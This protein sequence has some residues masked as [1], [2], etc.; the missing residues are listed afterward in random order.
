MPADHPLA[1]LCKVYSNVAFRADTVC[2]MALVALQPPPSR[3]AWVNSRVPCRII[4]QIHWKIAAN[5][6]TT[7]PEQTVFS[8]RQTEI[9]HSFSGNL[10][11]L[12]SP[13]WGSCFCGL[14]GPIDGGLLVN[15]CHWPW[16]L[17]L[18]VWNGL[19][20]RMMSRP[21]WLVSLV[22]SSEICGAVLLV[23]ISSLKLPFTAVEEK[24]EIRNY[25]VQ[26]FVI[27]RPPSCWHC[28]IN[29]IWDFLTKSCET[30]S[31]SSLQPQSIEAS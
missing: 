13:Y 18:S 19:R 4:Q 16:M 2:H 30:T 29:N 15:G 23:T 22:K 8:K 12:V 26:T 10:N 14:M 1:V 17:G 11:T 6:R 27:D 28:Y 5:I 3:R 31:G 25:E 9:Q 21:D 24:E 20:I 7:W